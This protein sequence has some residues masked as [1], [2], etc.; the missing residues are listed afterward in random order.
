M[1]VCQANS[2]SMTYS[3]SNLR[4][5]MDQS[6]SCR[7]R[8]QCSSRDRNHKNKDHCSGMRFLA[9]SNACSVRWDHMVLNL[10]PD[11]DPYYST[12]ARLR[13]AGK[14]GVGKD[15]SSRG[16]MSAS[17]AIVEEDGSI[18]DQIYGNHLEHVAKYQLRSQAFAHPA[19]QFDIELLCKMNRA[20]GGFLVADCC[21]V[22][23]TATHS[24]LPRPEV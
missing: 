5:M 12:F 7:Y 23:H 8:I 20:G 21:G 4:N 17:A 22:R 3:S 6:M 10:S 18:A 16:V 15:A 14:E 13:T 24:E 19:V 1:D 9:C 11:C 2:K